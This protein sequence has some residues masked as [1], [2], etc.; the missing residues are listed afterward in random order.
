MTETYQIELGNKM[1]RGM[2]IH[3]KEHIIGQRLLGKKESDWISGYLFEE[4]IEF[5]ENKYGKIR[6]SVESGEHFYKCFYK[7]PIGNIL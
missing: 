7:N 2:S 1:L 6:T 4:D 5:L 3:V